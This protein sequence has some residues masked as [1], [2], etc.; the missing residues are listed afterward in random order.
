MT[1]L[2][3]A[4]AVLWLATLAYLLI[5]LRQIVQVRRQLRGAW[6]RIRRR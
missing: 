2:I 1:V 5:V 6:R 4:L 3:V